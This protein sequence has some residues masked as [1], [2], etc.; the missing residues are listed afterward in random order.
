M[1]LCDWK[2]KLLSLVQV[3]AT[4]WTVACQ[5]PLSMGFFTQ[6]YWRRE[7]FPSTG[8]LPS[9]GV[10]CSLP[11]SSIHGILHAR[12]LEWVAYP[13]SRGSSQPRN[14]SSVSCSVG[15]FFTSWAIREA[16]IFTWDYLLLFWEVTIHFQFPLFFIFKNIVSYC[17]FLIKM[18]NNCFPFYFH[19]LAFN[20]TVFKSSLCLS[21]YLRKR[22][23]HK[24]Q[25]LFYY[26][27]L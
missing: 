18:W 15:R 13:F 10:N 1:F 23:I 3:F 21:K 4:S 24:S 9:P 14:L 20:D 16:I 26:C 25:T 2:W 22:K 5:T 17:N 6:E 12:L 11:D 8:N 27:I 19:V 7:L